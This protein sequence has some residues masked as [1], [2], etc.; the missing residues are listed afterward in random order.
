VALRDAFD[1]LEHARGDESLQ[2]EL[3]A[4]GLAARGADLV[5]LAAGA[6]FECTEAELAAAYRHD[7]AFRVLRYGRGGDSHG[8]TA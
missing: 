6:G 8:E 4:L 3:S 2:R 7:W 5:R 1:F